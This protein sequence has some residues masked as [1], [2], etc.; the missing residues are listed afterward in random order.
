MRTGGFALV[1]ETVQVIHTGHHTL[2]DQ[3][4]DS[5]LCASGE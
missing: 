2:R 1:P 5:G 4:D 3:I